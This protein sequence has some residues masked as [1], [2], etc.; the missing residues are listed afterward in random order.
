MTVEKYFEKN[1]CIYGISTKFEFG[2][3]YGY[4]R[5]FKNLRTAYDWLHTE[6]YDFRTRELVSL[7]NALEF[8][9]Y[10]Q[11]R[12]WKR[13]AKKRMIAVQD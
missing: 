9:D 7:T 10:D 8:A 12:I 11:A 4:A 3:W 2:R 1:G 6:E 13:S 5:R